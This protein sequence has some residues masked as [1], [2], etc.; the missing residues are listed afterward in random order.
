MMGVCVAPVALAALALALF[1]ARRPLSGRI[2][3]PH[4]ALLEDLPSDPARTLEAVTAW[5]THY[6]KTPRTW[7]DASGNL[8]YAEAVAEESALRAAFDAQFPLFL[9]GECVTEGSRLCKLS[10]AYCADYRAIFAAAASADI[11]KATDAV[12][13]APVQYV[14]YASGGND[15]DLDILVRAL[16][17][18]P[19]AQL[20]VHLVD[21]ENRHSVRLRRAIGASRRVTLTEG[22]DFLHADTRAA[23]DRI[24]AEDG[25]PGVRGAKQFAFG[26]ARN[27][28]RHVQFLAFLH[29]AF[30]A[31]QIA[32]HMHD[33]A[34]SYLV[35]VKDGTFPYPDVLTLADAENFACVDDALLP[36]VYAYAELFGAALTH[37]PASANLWLAKK[38]DYGAARLARIMPAGGTP[39]AEFADMQ[40]AVPLLLWRAALAFI[41]HHAPFSVPS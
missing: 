39:C 17:Q 24:V 7:F 15:L 1:A 34:E 4:P 8:S 31:A 2:P 9:L 37:N 3:T 23:I 11:V 40:C 38:D 26:V 20:T 29:R 25:N 19:Q 18:R 12:S 16:T 13:E 27:E 5:E 10:R 14:G 41:G 6:A 28:A 32:L 22:V 30:P 35:L 21:L 33:T 36:A